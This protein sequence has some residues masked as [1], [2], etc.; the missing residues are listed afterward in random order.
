MSIPQYWWVGVLGMFVLPGVLGPLGTGLQDEVVPVGVF[1]EMDPSPTLPE[2]WYRISLA[3]AF[4]ETTYE[5]VSGTHGAV[6]R[7][8]SENA[9]G[10]LATDLRVDLHTHP[11]LEWRWKV[12][13]IIPEAR[14]DNKFR[15]DSPARV[16]ISFDYDGL[17]LV[18][19]LQHV[20]M[21]ALGYD[22][23]P[24]RA[25]AYFWG[26]AEPR[27]VVLD[28][29]RAEWIQ[30][31][32][33]R[34]RADSTGAWVT[35]RRNVRADYRRIFGEDPPPVERVAFMTDTENTGRRVT[36]FYGDIVFRSGGPDTAHVDTMLHVQ[37]GEA[38]RH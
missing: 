24:T 1:S 34:N 38:G 36:A 6:V 33:V 17:D 8:R 20:A 13:T 30:M 28:N 25:I 18:Q 14:S 23:V 5:L 7:A 26:N 19:R 32:P 27:H 37:R 29:T 12:S 31:V 16:F 10:S 15:D 22:A 9:T 3:A 2:G 4:D 11:I 21:R 35:E